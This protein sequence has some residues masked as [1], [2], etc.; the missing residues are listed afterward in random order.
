MSSNIIDGKMHASNI[1]NKLKLE[2]S[3]IT[4]TYG[5]TPK[6]S[7]IIVGSDPASSLYVKNKANKAQSIGIQSEI[8]QL[9]QNITEDTL[10]DRIKKLNEDNTVHG[11]IVQLP[12]PKHINPSSIIMSIDPQKDV[13]GFHPINVGKLHNNDPT[14]LTPCTPLGCMYL[15]RQISSLSGKHAVVVGRSQIVGKPMSALLLQANCTVTICHSHTQNLCDIT[16][17]ADIVIAA[18]GRANFLDSEYFNSKA[19]IIDVGIN[20]VIQ[21]NKSHFIGDVDFNNVVNKVSY[22]TP[23]PGGVGPM[24]VAFLMSNTIKAATAILTQ[25]D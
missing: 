12:L 17:K 8:I 5:V 10:V 22:I 18:I 1:L 4:T 9:S 14:G 25:Q 15:L 16:S 13:D 11:I 2:V 6:L 3:D 24:T 20:S 23:V 19:I 7:V 21:N